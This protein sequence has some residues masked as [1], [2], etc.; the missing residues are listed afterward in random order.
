MFN[1]SSNAETD[2]D[3]SLPLN[4]SDNDKLIS[5]EIFQNITEEVDYD[6]YVGNM[7][8]ENELKSSFDELHEDAVEYLAGFIFKKFHEKHKKTFDRQGNPFT[9]TFVNCISEGGLTK[10]PDEFFAKIKILETIFMK[11]HGEKISKKHTL[12]FLL[13]V[14]T[15]VPLEV[16]CKNLFF[17]SRIY[18]RLKDLNLKHSFVKNKKKLRKMKKIIV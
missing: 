12:K 1:S 2:A 7:D 3:E 13:K 6:D 11:Y 17:R 9:H 15:N 10:P 5:G 14:S 16:E 8:E 4:W 18:F